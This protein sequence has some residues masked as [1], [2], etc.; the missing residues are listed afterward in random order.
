MGFFGVCQNSSTS[1]KSFSLG[2][3]RVFV[4]T[5]MTL[6]DGNFYQTSFVP[7][8]TAPC[9]FLGRKSSLSGMRRVRRRPRSSNGPESSPG[10]CRNLSALANCTCES[11]DVFCTLGNVVVPG[12][13]TRAE[14][15]RMAT[16]TVGR[17]KILQEGP[18]NA[19][20]HPHRVL[21]V[22]IIVLMLL[23]LINCITN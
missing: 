12:D 6:L 23:N 19:S 15:T 10:I 20:G 14:Q 1:I 17:W 8:Q 5:R 21:C 22:P 4:S 18:A 7:F 16:G 13:R 11:M 2:Y 3:S 9:R